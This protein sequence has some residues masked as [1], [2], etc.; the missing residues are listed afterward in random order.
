MSTARIPTKGWGRMEKEMQ[1]QASKQER[2]LYCVYEAEEQGKEVFEAILWFQ[3]LPGN[4]QSLM[5]DTEWPPLIMIMLPPPP[6][7]ERVKLV[8]N[9]I[10]NRWYPSIAFYYGA[11]SLVFFINK[12]RNPP[13]TFTGS[14]LILP[15]KLSNLWLKL[16]QDHSWESIQKSFLEIQLRKISY[17]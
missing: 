15:I 7:R 16:L 2:M 4:Y 1:S 17:H 6:Q 3:C 13:E 12:R 11:R 5:R 10:L 14:T 9:I 8:Y